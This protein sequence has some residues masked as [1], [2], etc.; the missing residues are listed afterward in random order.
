MFAGVE[1]STRKVLEQTESALSA[2][3]LGFERGEMWYDVDGPEDLARLT[4][5]RELPDYT[6]RRLALKAQAWRP[7]Q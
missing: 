7:V 1:W 4:A 6:R 2:C 5:E 3:G